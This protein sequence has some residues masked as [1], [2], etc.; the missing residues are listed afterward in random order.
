MNSMIWKIFTTIFRLVCIIVAIIMASKCYVRYLKEETSYEMTFSKFN[1]QPNSVYPSVSMCFSMPFIKERLNKLVQGVTP[2]KYQSFLL[3]HTFEK[4]FQNI[5]YEDVSL[6]LDE[7]L[8]SSELVKKST[9]ESDNHTNISRKDVSVKSLNLYNWRILKCFTIDIPFVKNNL[10]DGLYITIKR[11]VFPGGIRPMDGWEHPFGLSFYYHQPEH[12]FKA[13]SSRRVVWPQTSLQNYSV[14][15]YVSHIEVFTR[16]QRKGRPCKKRENYDQWLLEHL[17]S[18]E[19]CVPPYWNSTKGIP[20]CQTKEQFKKISERFWTHFYSNGDNGE[21][22]PPCREIRKILVEYEDSET[23]PRIPDENLLLQIYFRQSNF[24]E[25]SERREYDEQTLF[26][27]VGGY[28]GL[29]LGYAIVGLP[30]FLLT[31]L[32]LFRSY[33]DKVKR[34]QSLNAALIDILNESRNTPDNENALKHGTSDKSRT[35]HDDSALDT[36]STVQKDHLESGDVF[37][38]NGSI[39]EIELPIVG[40]TDTKIRDIELLKQR[41]TYLEDVVLRSKT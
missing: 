36:K 20:S 13:F 24:K 31:A 26:G 35:N 9:N 41:L 22:T 17:M 28:V 38:E 4:E 21:L 33:M 3:G 23:Y 1:G 16:R 2:E 32:V 11:S 27:D 19:N 39:V 40:T 6:R 25:T 18:T 34:N 12:F 15:M 30:D 7:F 37:I 10:I 14:V 29:I 8:V 5:S